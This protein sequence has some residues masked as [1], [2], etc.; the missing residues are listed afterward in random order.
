MQLLVLFGLNGDVSV[1]SSILDVDFE[2]QLFLRTLIC[3]FISP[4]YQ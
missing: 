4:K 3:P 1:F 2:E